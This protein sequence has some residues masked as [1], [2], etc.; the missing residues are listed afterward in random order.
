MFVIVREGPRL[1]WYDS[2][3]DFHLQIKVYKNLKTVK[4]IYFLNKASENYIIQKYI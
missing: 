4:N 3:W 1:G 2:I